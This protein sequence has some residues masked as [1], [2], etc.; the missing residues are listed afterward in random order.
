M[1]L[2]PLRDLLYIIPIREPSQVGKIVRPDSHQRRLHQGVV[3]Y[4]GPKTTGDIKRGDHIFFH[5]WGGYEI[6]MEEEGPLVTIKESL[7][8]FVLDEEKDAAYLIPLGS[9]DLFIERVLAEFNRL[10]NRTDDERRIATKLVDRMKH[11]LERK[12]F[13]ELYF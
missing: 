12:F 7:V 9:V 6:V 11:R 10:S 3:K 4:R 2:R 8:D 5:A 13:D 1:A